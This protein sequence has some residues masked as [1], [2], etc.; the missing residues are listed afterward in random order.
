MLERAHPGGE[1][2]HFAQHCHIQPAK[3]T[4][5][6]ASR[7]TDK[8]TIIGFLHEGSRAPSGLVSAP[9]KAG[10]EAQIWQWSSLSQPLGPD[11]PK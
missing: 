2:K 4:A 5:V 10:R 7:C 9:L 6:A 11:L 3:S 8:W 1:T